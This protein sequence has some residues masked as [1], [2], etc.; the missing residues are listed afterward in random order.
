MAQPKPLKKRLTQADLKRLRERKMT[1]LEAA[2]KY[3][4]S[5]SYLSRTVAAIQQKQRG[6]VV[7]AREGL[8]ILYATRQKMRILQAQRAKAGTISVAQ[9]ATNANCS[10]RTMRRYIENYT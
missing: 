6:K 3:G 2:Q 1:N 9:A 8:S 7:L 4:V 5:E 10:E